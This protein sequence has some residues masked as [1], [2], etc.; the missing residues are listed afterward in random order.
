MASDT[1]VLVSWDH[2]DLQVSGYIVY[3]T[4]TNNSTERSLRVSNTTHSVLIQN[5]AYDEIY[6]FEV[7]VFVEF[8]GGELISQKSSITDT[9]ILR[10]TRLGMHFCTH[11]KWGYFSNIASLNFPLIFLS[12]L[13]PQSRS[14]LPFLLP[15]G[16]YF[17]FPLLSPPPPPPSFSLSSTPSPSLLYPFP[18]LSSSTTYAQLPPPN[19]SKCVTSTSLPQQPL[20]QLPF[21]SLSYYSSC[22]VS[23]DHA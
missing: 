6:T 5:L 2:V 20:P 10:T 8:D 23:V 15:F 12:L 19:H 11:L 14:S 9:T 4:Q 21:S 1:S 16:L 3:H 13:N 22:A 18:I 17:F 7:A